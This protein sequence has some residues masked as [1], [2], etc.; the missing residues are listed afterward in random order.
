MKKKYFNEKK[1]PF[2]KFKNLIGKTSF[3]D[4]A[5]IARLSSCVIGK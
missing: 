4:L 2:I 1:F 5:E 3:L